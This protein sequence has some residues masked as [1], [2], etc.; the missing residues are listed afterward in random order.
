[1]RKSAIVVGLGAFLVTLGLLLK[2]YAFPRLAV[3]PYDQ[4]TGQ[5]LTDPKAK[6]FDAD[7]LKFKQ[8]PIT[9]T[10]T[11]VGNKDAAK[12]YGRNSVMINYWQYTDNNGTPPPMS[13]TTASY[14]LDRNTGKAL[15]WAGSTLNG[16]PVDF[17]N[18]YIIKLPF[19][20]QKGK[21]YPYFDT[22]LGKP[23]QLNY[24]G[25]EKIMGMETYKYTASVP[26]TTYMKFE[27]PGF[28]FGL[29]K[30]SP[31]QNADRTYSNDYTIWADPITGV[32]MKMSQHQKQTFKIPGRPAV[33]ILDTTSTMTEATVKKNVDEYKSKGFQL[34]A[35]K[36][37][38]WALIPLGLILLI[39][40][41]ILALITGNGRRGRRRAE[42]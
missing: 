24:A 34:N 6:F 40:G 25:T 28:L 20:L 41:L 27:A 39:G 3:I 21:S 36:A 35:L 1:M 29:G 17:Q 12:K 11:V 38:P 32:F 22:T 16:R 13:A 2:F 19:G 30:E 15:N 42:S 10:A 14:A 7:T 26:D 33:N 23:V 8:E 31:G 18:A 5:T 9:T 37:A 4:N